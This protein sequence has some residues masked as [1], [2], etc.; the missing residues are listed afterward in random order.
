MSRRTIMAKKQLNLANVQIG[1]R[2]FEGREGTYNNKGDRS[3]VIF[4]DNKMA[5]D[6]EM[7]GWNIKWPTAR[8]DVSDEED[9]RQPFLK[10]SVSFEY[11]P[12][13]IYLIKEM[14]DEEPNVEQM[15]EDSVKSLDWAEL[16]NVDVVIRPYEWTVSGKSGIKAYL[17]AGYFTLT[18]DAFGR[19][20]G[21]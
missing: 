14:E 9:S 17:K 15:F 11:Y 2:N 5:T 1:F 10:V 3:F 20:Y 6:L 8:P 13:K 21:V 18:N 4:L 16:S 12:A 7:D 19:K